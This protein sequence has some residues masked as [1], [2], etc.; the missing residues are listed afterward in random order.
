MHRPLLLLLFFLAFLAACGAPAAS[1]EPPEA[2]ALKLVNAFATWDELTMQELIVP[3]GTSAIRLASAGNAWSGFAG[4]IGAFQS[5]KVTKTEIRG[6]RAAITVEAVHAEKSGFV[7]I[8]LERIDGQ[9]KARTW[10]I[11][12]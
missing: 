11:Y 3:D 9:W 2:V 7:D 5:A 10:N 1:Q 12:R 8:T 6:S 4:R